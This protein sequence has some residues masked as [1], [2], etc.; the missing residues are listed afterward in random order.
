M[1][2]GCFVATAL[3]NRRQPQSGY[4]TNHR[5]VKGAAS[6]SKADEA[7]INHRRATRCAGIWVVKLELIKNRVIRSAPYYRIRKWKRVVFEI[8]RIEFCAFPKKPEKM[9]GCSR[10]T[11]PAKWLVTS[12][13]ASHRHQ[14][15]GTPALFAGAAFRRIRPDRSRDHAHRSAD[16]AVHSALVAQRFAGWRFASRRVLWFACGRLVVQP[17]YASL[18]RAH[19]ARSRLSDDRRGSRFGQHFVDDR[20][21]VRAWSSGN[22]LWPGRASHE[23]RSSRNRRRAKRFLGEPC[24]FRV[25]SG[26]RFVLSAGFTRAEKW[27]SS[28]ISL[29]LRGSW[30]LTG[31]FVSLCKVP[32]SKARSV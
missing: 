4:S 7:H 15:R 12:D 6:K 3:Q 26:S 5:R 19:F 23:S 21:P 2:L 25:G 18:R 8:E 13:H 28:D 10:R 9:P 16:A 29:R 1:F 17:N 24:Q 32:R 27:I 14:R 11:S 30:R 22:W 20:R 31:V